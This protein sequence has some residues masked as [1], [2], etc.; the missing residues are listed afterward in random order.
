MAGA[1]EETV[2]SDELRGLSAARPIVAGDAL[3]TC[4]EVEDI[5]DEVSLPS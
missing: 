2:E 5:E 4:G 1:T 3:G